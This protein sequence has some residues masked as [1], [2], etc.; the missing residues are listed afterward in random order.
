MSKIARSTIPGL[1]ICIC[2]F[3]HLLIGFGNGA[4]RLVSNSPRCGGGYTAATPPPTVESY[5]E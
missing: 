4:D 1:P 2:R 5:V 3:V